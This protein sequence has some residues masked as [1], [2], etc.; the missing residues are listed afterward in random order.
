MDHLF[1]RRAPLAVIVLAHSAV[2]IIC[3]VSYKVT[4]LY[5]DEWGEILRKQIWKYMQN[6]ITSEFSVC[7]NFVE[8]FWTA[9]DKRWCVLT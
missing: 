7:I 4:A 1:H 5:S 9:L 2:H 8:S 3:V 6:K